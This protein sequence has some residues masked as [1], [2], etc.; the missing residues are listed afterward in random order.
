MRLPLLNLL[1]S[2]LVAL[3]YAQAVKQQVM[4]TYP[5]ETPNSVMQEAMEVIRA[6]GGIITH[7]FS[8]LYQDW[9]LHQDC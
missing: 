1:L 6:A 8:V 5:E 7:E 4:I 3:V 2:F 9:E